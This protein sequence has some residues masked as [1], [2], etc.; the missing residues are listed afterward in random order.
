MTEREKKL[1][2]MLAQN[3][4]G[5]K[6]AANLESILGKLNTPENQRSLEGFKHRPEATKAMQGDAQAMSAL[7]QNMM[8]SDQGKQL[9][10]QVRKAT[11][12]V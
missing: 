11:E 9:M 5:A 12:G 7:L 8:A 2:Q 4:K 1:Q 6:A 3:P 10:E